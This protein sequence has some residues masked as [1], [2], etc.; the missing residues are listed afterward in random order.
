MTDK[1]IHRALGKDREHS[2]KLR[3]RTGYA[4]AE[5]PARGVFDTHRATT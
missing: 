2:A 5:D 1:V 3:N 4:G